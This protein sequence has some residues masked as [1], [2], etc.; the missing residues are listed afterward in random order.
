MIYLFNKVF[1]SCIIH[2]GNRRCI[3]P[4]KRLF[5]SMI[6]PIAPKQEIR[7][8]FFYLGH[9]NMDIHNRAF[10]V[11]GLDFQFSSYILAIFAKHSIDFR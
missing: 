7:L 2:R 4:R 6:N 5:S 1:E 10:V 3:Y 8:S 9:T 11:I